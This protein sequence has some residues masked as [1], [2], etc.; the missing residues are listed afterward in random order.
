MNSMRDEGSRGPARI[1][2]ASEP[3]LSCRSQ[4]PKDSTILFMNFPGPAYFSCAAA[5]LEHSA[6]GVRKRHCCLRLEDQC[7]HLLASWTALVSSLLEEGN[8]LQ[9]GK[10]VPGGMVSGEVRGQCRAE[11][12]WTKGYLSVNA[13]VFI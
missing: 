12:Q 13:S 11:P 9:L 8:F 3:F 5:A 1:L 10:Q 4:E 6:K 7:Q 2:Q